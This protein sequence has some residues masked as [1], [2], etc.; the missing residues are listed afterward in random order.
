[1]FIYSLQTNIVKPIMQLTSSIFVSAYYS[2]WII[3][4]WEN[5][6]YQYSTTLRRN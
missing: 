4:K 2:Q 5:K 3:Y 1:M 6:I